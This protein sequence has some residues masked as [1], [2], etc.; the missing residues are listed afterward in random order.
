MVIYWKVRMQ[1]FN[2]RMR[3]KKA[4]KIQK[5]R[6]IYLNIENENSEDDNEEDDEE[7]TSFFIY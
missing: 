2:Y 6:V 3:V 1:I 4:M 7:K 5:K